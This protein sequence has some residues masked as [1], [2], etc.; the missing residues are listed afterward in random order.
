MKFYLQPFDRF[1][2]YK[3][4]TQDIFNLFKH[5]QIY[6]NKQKFFQSNTLRCSE[7]LESQSQLP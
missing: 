5:S 6:K 4:I 1:E 3:D 2:I 7:A